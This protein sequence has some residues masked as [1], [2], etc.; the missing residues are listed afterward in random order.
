MG[1]ANKR[2]RN[3]VLDILG[4]KCSSPNCKWVNLDGS[5]GCTDVRCLQLDHKKGGGGRHLKLISG[6][7]ASYRWIVENP[8]LVGEWFQLLCANCNWIKRVENEE[9]YYLGKAA[10][11]LPPF[12]RT[13]ITQRRT[14]E[15]LLE[16]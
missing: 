8:S 13:P 10:P 15:P 12:R 14:F 1:A 7:V 3:Q 4:R 2:L 11:K 6:S 9:G 16:G 5:I